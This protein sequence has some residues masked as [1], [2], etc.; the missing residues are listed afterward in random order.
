M[1]IVN[2]NERAPVRIGCAVPVTAGS[3]WSVAAEPG[4]LDAVDAIAAAGLDH[5]M[6]GDHVSFRDGAGADGLLQAA[7]ALGHRP[8]LPV[9][10]AVYLLGLRHPVTVARQVADLAALAPGRLVLGVGLGG[11]DRHEVESCGVD[12]ATRGARTDESLTVLRGLLDGETVSFSGRH[13]QVRDAR[14]RPVPADPVPIV[15]GGRSDA[16]LGRAARAGDGWI[17]IWVSAQR[18][19]DSVRLVEERA[20]GYGRDVKQWAHALNVWCGLDSST[21][22]AERAVAA[23][24]RA[25]YDLPYETFA[26]WS[27]AGPPEHVAAFLAPYLEAGCSTINL[28]PCGLDR[29]ETIAMAAQVRTLLLNEVSAWS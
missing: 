19:A 6:L 23:G 17:G 12:P 22:G 14:I 18:Y 3:S 27:P 20:D 5:L 11:E 28:I 13:I 4:A 1:R 29:D 7:V 21:A 10:V 2:A 9:Y 15:V 8:E 26:R 16:A 25:F 24:M